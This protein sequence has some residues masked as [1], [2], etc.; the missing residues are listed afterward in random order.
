MASKVSKTDKTYNYEHGQ[1]N[2]SVSQY[3]T[4]FT[5]ITKQQ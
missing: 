4:H 5:W 2:G 3:I 1:N